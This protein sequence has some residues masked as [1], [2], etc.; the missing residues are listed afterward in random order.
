MKDSSIEEIWPLTPLQAGFLFHV[1]YDDQAADVYTVQIG[2]DLDGKLNRAALK[3]A[4]AHLLERH[5]NLRVRFVIR[6][7]SRPVQIV[8]RNVVLPWSEIDLSGEAD[9]AAALERLQA[10][11]RSRRF[12]ITQPPLLRF[13][14]VALGQG[15]HRHCCC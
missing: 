12:D 2:L 11:E 9:Q 3:A 1:I 7:C 15:R 6:A 5:A 8:L 13:V 4:A 10:Q 14:L